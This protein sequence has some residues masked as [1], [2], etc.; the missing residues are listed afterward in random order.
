M[1]REEYIS[2]CLPSG[3]LYITFHHFISVTS[4]VEYHLY[5]L[6]SPKSPA[7][8]LSLTLA[9]MKL[10]ALSQISLFVL[11]IAIQ[12]DSLIDVLKE[13]GASNFA[14]QIEASP[15]LLS[16][17]TSS[18]VKTV[19]AI[20]DSN[21]TYSNSTLR[22]RADPIQQAQIQTSNDISDFQTY[23]VQPG[24][25]Q[26][27]N[28]KTPKLKGPQ[29]VVPETGVDQD[30]QTPKRRGVVYT[31]ATVPSSPIKIA[32]GLGKKVNLLRGNIAYDGGVIHI[33]DG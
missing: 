4:V 25:I 21:N 33:V 10:L 20:Q 13:N 22:K 24:G 1:R 9:K 2:P 23:N 14:K 32:S 8:T 5:F 16:Y 30:E 26:E 28:L 7:K 19:Y 15:D 27:T 11:P 31:N 29:V 3:A 6:L 17:Y 18:S 12:A